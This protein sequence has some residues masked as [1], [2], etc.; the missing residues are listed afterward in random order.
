MKY[1]KLLK[2]SVYSLELCNVVILNSNFPW[3]I[4][5][6]LIMRSV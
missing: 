1:K 4:D 3:N 5:F 2:K 6:P